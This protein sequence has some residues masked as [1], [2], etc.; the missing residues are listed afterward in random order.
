MP[1]STKISRRMYITFDGLVEEAD[2]KLNETTKIG[3]HLDQ[4]EL[5]WALGCLEVIK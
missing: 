3:L 1:K 2:G 4:S 5:M